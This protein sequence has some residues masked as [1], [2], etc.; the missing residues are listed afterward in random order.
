MTDN[1]ARF[2]FNRKDPADNKA[3][4]FIFII[5]DNGD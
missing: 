4:S 1:D 5:S 2:I 3:G